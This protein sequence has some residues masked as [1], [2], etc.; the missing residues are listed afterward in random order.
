M[1]VQHCRQGDHRHIDKKT[2]GV[3]TDGA[4][5]FDSVIPMSVF[6]CMRE[7]YAKCSDAPILLLDQCPRVLRSEIHASEADTIPS[8]HTLYFFSEF[9]SI[10]NCTFRVLLTLT[11]GLFIKTGTQ[12]DDY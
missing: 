2:S 1:P 9:I 5:Y 6:F 12:N 4:I 10:L 7:V 3:S 11:A 8:S